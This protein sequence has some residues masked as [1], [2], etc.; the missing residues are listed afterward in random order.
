MTAVSTARIKL[1]FSIEASLQKSFVQQYRWAGKVPFISC[2][3]QID[4]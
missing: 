3:V 4:E 1:A 2:S